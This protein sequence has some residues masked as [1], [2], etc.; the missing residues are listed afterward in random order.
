M[1]RLRFAVAFGEGELRLKSPSKLRRDKS[2][3]MHYVYIQKC[4]DNR[5]YV[6]CTN[7]LQDRVKRHQKG[8]IPATANRLP[9]ALV[10]YAAFLD[11]HRAFGFEKYLKSGSGR[12]FM[13]RHLL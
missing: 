3:F 11:N 12:A 2:A 10:Y 7:N 13:K 9:V 5:Y 6:G 8:Y 4:S 1:A